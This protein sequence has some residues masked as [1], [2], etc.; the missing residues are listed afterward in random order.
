VEFVRLADY[1]PKLE[2]L[3]MDETV[4]KYSTHLVF[5]TSSDN[6]RE[7]EH[8][9][10]YSILTRKPKRADIYWFVHVDTVDDP[11]TCEYTVEH[12]MPNDIIRIDFHLGFRVQPRIN[13]LFKKV[14]E[15]LAQ[16]REI[17]VWNKYDSVGQR[18]IGG[19][20][21]FIVLEKYLSHD[22]QLPFMDKMVMKLYFFLKG[23][24]LSEERSFGLDPSTVEV[25][26]F[27]LVVAPVTNLYLKRIE[28]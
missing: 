22:N 7:L 21:S 11:Y 14:V 15:E 25:E 16:N 19:D 24:S 28:S 17:S 18:G 20:F 4:P 13:L 8:K 26:K 6:P 10:I 5:L 3:S 23:V 27:P 12:V 2:E 1:V 9:I